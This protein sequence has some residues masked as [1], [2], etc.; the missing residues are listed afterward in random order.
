M[1]A[2]TEGLL[3]N[4]AQA[5]CE[6]R[7]ATEHYR[8]AVEHARRAGDVL[9]ASLFT[10]YLASVCHE[11]GDLEAAI[12]GYDEA[13]PEVEAAGAARHLALFTAA[14]SAAL[15]A[16][17]ERGD[18]RALVERL[19]ER[20]DVAL[21]AAIACFKAVWHLAEARVAH[22][23]G[24]HETARWH[25]EAAADAAPPDAVAAHDDVAIATRVLDA[26]VAEATRVRPILQLGPGCVWM[27]APGHARV[28]LT[29]RD[30]P[31]R[32]LAALVEALQRP[33]ASVTTDSLLEA[34][35][36]GERILPDA[37]RGR[38]KTAVWTLRRA[39]LADFLQTAPRGY[40]LSPDLAVEFDPD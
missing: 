6:P 24:E 2:E 11:E 14:K 28:D 38:L 25:R 18:A 37:A 15:A 27:N 36:P 7:Q 26:A 12:A 22:A 13:L 20:D 23:T 31:R 17:G 5:A 3:G 40:R 30:A 35:W 10:G 32:I 21:T 16:R 33:C 39:G 9:L 29:G 1:A 19:A 8:R 34:G 4:L